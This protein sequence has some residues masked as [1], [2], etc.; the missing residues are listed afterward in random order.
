MPSIE[1]V[2]GQKRILEAPK[3]T[4][5]KRRPP[6]K[7][8][9]RR[10]TWADNRLSMELPARLVS[11][12]NAHEHWRHRSN[13][14]KSQR[15]L[16]ATCLNLSVGK[17]ELLRCLGP[18]DVKITRLAPRLLDQNNYQTSVK[19]VQD[20]IA[21]WLQIDDRHIELVRYIVMQE[22]SKYYGVRIDIWRR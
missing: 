20:G 21:A 22:K 9:Q 8:A 6:P 2:L 13:R 14:A 3:K 18:L 16:V 11:E 5:K 7:M 4:P 15:Q 12:S 1:D 10:W 19:H 17:P